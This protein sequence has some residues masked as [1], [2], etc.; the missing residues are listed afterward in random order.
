MNDL[1]EAMIKATMTVKA[2]R[3]ILVTVI[4]MVVNISNISSTHKYTL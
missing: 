1:T 3:S 4:V 2:E